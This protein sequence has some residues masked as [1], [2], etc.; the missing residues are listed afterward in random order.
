MEFLG[1]LGEFFVGLGLLLM[2]CAAIWFVS[3]YSDKTGAKQ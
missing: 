3:T 1:V 2:G